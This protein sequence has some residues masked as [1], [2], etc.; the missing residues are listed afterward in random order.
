MSLRIVSV[1]YNNKHTLG[2]FLD[3]LA[4]HI[5]IPCEI[6]LWDNG[7]DMPELEKYLITHP[8]YPHKVLKGSL[9]MNL[10]FSKAANLA[11]KLPSASLPEAYLFL[12]PDGYL[13]SPITPALYKELLA[14]NALLGLRVFDDPAKTSRQASARSFPG[15]STTLSGR[16]GL[17]TKF[18]PSNP[19]SKRYLNQEIDPNLPRR[20]DWV[21]GCA[22]FAPAPL[23][24]KL[25]GFDDAYFLYVED[26][27][28][29][30]KAQSLQIPVWYFPRIDVVHTIKGSSEGK[31][32][33][34]DVYHHRGMWRYHLKW[35]G[36]FMKLLS[37]LVGLGILAR[38][39]VKR[40]LP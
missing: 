18:W 15:I 34:P 24:E 10:G 35:S 7:N 19:W 27:D 38:F 33:W 32:F 3:S 22:L 14:Q 36:P 21:S 23:W 39:F 9:S 5:S 40:I 20:V 8:D 26:V 28:L 12:N 31:S 16:E 11:S 29:G 25:G 1:L 37:P 6:A 4:S 30:R 17:L 13:A 2:D